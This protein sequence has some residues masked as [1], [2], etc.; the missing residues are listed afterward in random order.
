[1]GRAVEL[2]LRQTNEAFDMLRGRLA[3]LTDEEY[4][5]EPV[6]GGWTLRVL[7]DGR[8][9]ADYAYPDPDP[10]PFTTIGWRINHIA[11]CKVMYH[12]YAYGP[13]KL[14]FPDLDVPP[15][16]AEAASMLEEGHTLLTTDLDGLK[17]ADLE[18]TVLTNW[19]EEWPA[20]RIFWTM[21]HHDLWHGG[22]IGA[23]RDL[24]R[25]SRSQQAAP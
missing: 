13:G 4:L 19:G 11:S 7:P 17:D 10:P 15:T 18:A 23:L 6:S 5:W 21:I 1:M 9:D 20:W 25:E 24:Y 2:L 14:T 8:L 3:G 22:E 16:P 12:E